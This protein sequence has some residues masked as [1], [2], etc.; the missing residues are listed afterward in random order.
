MCVSHSRP[1]GV[2]VLGYQ[3][4]LLQRC[5]PVCGHEGSSHLSPVLALR[6]FIAM[7]VQYPYNSSTDGG[8]VLL[9]KDERIQILVFTRIELT[10]SALLGVRGYLLDHSG[11]ECVDGRN[12]RNEQK[13]VDG[14]KSRAYVK[15]IVSVES[16]MIRDVRHLVGC[17]CWSAQSFC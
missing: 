2:N 14:V 11:D 4:Q 12:P 16:P 9:T 8:S 1:M 3:S 13:K 5:H 10:T 17:T 6:F 7:H 15:P